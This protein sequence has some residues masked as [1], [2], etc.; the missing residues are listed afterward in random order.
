MV[1]RCKEDAERTRDAILDAAEKLFFR[2]GVSRT[3]LEQI[4]REAGVTRGA[5]YWHFRNKVEVSDAMH[6][7]VELPLY[8]L[9]EDLAATPPADPVAALRQV[10]RGT[11]ERLAESPCLQR[12]YA[13]LFHKCEDVE[14]LAS[15][16]ERHSRNERRL[17]V[18][19]ESVFGRIA[20][21]GRLAPAMD[22]PAAARSL[23]ALLLGATGAALHEHRNFDLRRDT[24]EVVDRFFDCVT[25]E[26]ESAP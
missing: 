5:I 26:P 21:A 14:E 2:N 25:L 23:Y 17:L 22:P 12:V 20:E 11:L 19:L 4:A 7:R 24:I 15:S 16:A 6:A 8:A 18:A 1:R 3:S 9:V 13:I 10:C